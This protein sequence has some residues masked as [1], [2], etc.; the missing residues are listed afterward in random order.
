VIACDSAPKRRRRRR[1]RRRSRRGAA[2][3]GAGAKLV[4]GG[5]D[6]EEGG[7]RGAVDDGEE[8]VGVQHV[9]RRLDLARHLRG[10]ARPRMYVKICMRACMHASCTH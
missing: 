8:L 1:R 3:G 5:V 2:G 4:G 6:E 10:A 9:V 7:V